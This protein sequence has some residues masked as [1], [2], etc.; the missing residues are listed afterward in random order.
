MKNYLKSLLFILLTSILAC[1]K[2]NPPSSSNRI[3]LLTQKEWVVTATRLQKNNDPWKDDLSVLLP[4]ERDNRMLF[5]KNGTY[6]IL[7]G[8]TKCNTSDPNIIEENELWALIQNESKITMS[9]N[10]GWEL[11]I[12]L[13]DKNTFKILH[14][15]VQNGNS[16]KEETTL[17]HP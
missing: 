7:E 8:P 17:T 11:T 9:H 1:K 2:D 3:M 15:Y 10:G 14:E 12:V 5:D 6:D 16:Y 4:C 13:L